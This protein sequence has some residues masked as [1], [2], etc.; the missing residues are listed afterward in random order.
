MYETDFFYQR[1]CPSDEVNMTGEVPENATKKYRHKMWSR[2]GDDDCRPGDTICQDLKKVEA[3]IQ[4]NGTKSTLIRLEV[5]DFR[6]K[7]PSLYA[8]GSEPIKGKF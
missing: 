1:T 6:P 3:K 5:W 4:E 7:I 8:T 2:K